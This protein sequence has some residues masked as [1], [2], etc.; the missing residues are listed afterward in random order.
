MSLSKPIQKSSRWRLRQGERRI[1]L[2]LGD[3][4]MASLALIIGLYV[5]AI[6]EINRLEFVEFL[7]LRPDAWIFF[8][9]I[10]WIFLLIESY[11]SHRASDWGKTVSAVTMAALIGIGLYMLIFFI[12]PR[13]LPRRGVAGFVLAASLLTMLWRFVYIR[14]FTAPRFMRR[15]LLVGA[16][17]T[18]QAILKVIKDLWPPPF[19]LV[20]LVDDDEDK[21]GKEILGYKV[22]GGNESLLEVVTEESISD[23][24]VAISGRMLGRMFQS[25]LDAQELGVEIIRMPV[26]YE[27]LLGRVPV[28]HLEADWILRSFV[29]EARVGSFYEIGKRLLDIIGGLVG[30]VVLALIT[31]FIS[32]AIY[33]EGGRPIVF[34]QTR[35]GRGGHPYTIIKF[36]TMHQNAERDGAQL[37]QENDERTT[38]LGRFLRKTRLDEW[39]QFINVLRGEM[40]MVGP[41]PERPELVQ[42]FQQEI[43]FYRG[44]LLDKPGITGW[45][46]V[47]FGYASNIEEM[48]VKLEYDLYYIKHR[49]I[50]LD[51]I[52][53]LRTF[54]TVLGFRGQ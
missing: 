40:S 33:L 38:G 37:A 27:E 10:L 25:L 3:S 30:V 29:D 11:D 41:R 12:D 7:K 52:I 39:P 20:G 9:P 5:W 2:V 36:R 32:L 42:H 13:S 14:V 49:N 1:I 31:P 16:G 6:A 15:V 18:G 51:V 44:R 8:L 23:I 28:Q 45:A 26:A 24:V 48:V 34:R 35:A 22:F 43:P 46:Q 17:I 4:V 50:I 54:G 21:I 47:N 53:L 19:Y